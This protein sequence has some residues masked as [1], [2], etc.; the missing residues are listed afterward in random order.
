[1]TVKFLFFENALTYNVYMYVVMK[2]LETCTTS[3]TS[4]SSNLN[5]HLSY[6]LAH[7]YRNVHNTGMTNDN[8]DNDILTWT[9]AGEM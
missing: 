4:M 9:F 1:M 8:Y 6:P 3:L 5:Y 7:Q 2:G